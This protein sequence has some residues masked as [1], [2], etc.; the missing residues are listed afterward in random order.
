MI[1]ILEISMVSEIN[2]VLVSRV[3]LETV[4][5]QFEFEFDR[6]TTS[7]RTDFLVARETRS[8]DREDPLC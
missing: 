8:L 2:N 6:F 7:R 4:L 3:S 1:G 5:V